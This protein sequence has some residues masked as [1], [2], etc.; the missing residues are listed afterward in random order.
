MGINKKLHTRINAVLIGTVIALCTGFI[1]LSSYVL[2]QTWESNIFCITIYI[3]ALSLLSL[4]LVAFTIKTTCRKSGKELHTLLKRF[5]G[6][7][8]FTHRSSVEISE[9]A[10]ALDEMMKELQDLLQS[11]RAKAQ[12]IDRDVEILTQGIHQVAADQTNLFS[13]SAAIETVRSYQDGFSIISGEILSLVERTGHLT[14]NVRSV[15]DQL[16]AEVDEFITE[17]EHVL[18]RFDPNQIG[19]LMVASTDAAQEKTDTP[20][21]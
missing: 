20:L 2:I 10:T 13:L 18:R 4:G 1:I 8:G 19:A 6:K 9:V 3:I 11:V 16:R 12:A 5:E 7:G 15:A 21:T 14:E 17:L